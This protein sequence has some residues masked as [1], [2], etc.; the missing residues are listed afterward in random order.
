M[1]RI[2]LPKKKNIFLYFLFHRSV[3]KVFVKIKTSQSFQRKYIQYWDFP[4]YV[5][6]SCLGDTYTSVWESQ[7]PGCNR[8]WC[9][10]FPACLVGIS[11]ARVL[12]SYWP[13][14]TCQQKQ[15]EWG[16]LGIFLQHYAVAENSWRKVKTFKDWFVLILIKQCL[17]VLKPEGKFRIL[18]EEPDSFQMS[19][20]LTQLSIWP[21]F[22][23]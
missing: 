23:G 6:W 15:F 9:H 17:E 1:L 19:F 3:M 18:L 22:S 21:C 5:L 14:P 8:K 2:L 13:P 7:P 20:L 12:L 11:D 10:C 4:Q 16:F